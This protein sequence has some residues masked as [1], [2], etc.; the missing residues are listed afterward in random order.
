VAP[1]PAIAQAPTEVVEYYAVDAVGSVRVVF[2]A[3]GNILGRADYTPFGG[4]LFSG[5]GLPSLRF[6]GL[7]RDGEAG[8]DYAQARSYQVRTGRF[9]APD[10]VYAGMFDPQQWN[11]YAYAASRPLTFTDVSGLQAQQVIHPNC[12]AIGGNAYQYSCGPPIHVGNV[13]VDVTAK[14]PVTPLSLATLIGLSL[15]GS[16]QPSLVPQGPTPSM[17]PSGGGGSGVSPFTLGL[18]W[19]TG[20]GERDRTFVDGDPMTEQLKEHSHI[21]R[22]V[23]AVCGGSR[24]TSGSAPYNL[25]GFGGV[26][27]Y[28]AD[29]S[30]IATAGLTGNTAVT[31]LGSYSLNYSMSNGVVQMTVR[32]SSTVASGFRPPVVGYTATWDRYVGEPLNAMFSSGPM[33]RTTQTF[34]FG[35]ACQ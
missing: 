29:Y 7:F 18:E 17:S 31:F 15:A 25:S 4:E 1:V 26:P 2:D 23:R 16:S 30:T 35:V 19:L 21:K 9:N 10:P 14:A 20:E 11:R 27:K 34:N 5:Q 13:N 33:S 3:T 12:T 6:A 32:N 8:L 24:P 28:L 22:V